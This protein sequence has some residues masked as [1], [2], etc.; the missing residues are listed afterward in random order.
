MPRHF[1]VGSAAS[2][3]DISAQGLWLSGDSD[4]G[5]G[6]GAIGVRRGIHSGTGAVER[7]GGGG[8]RGGAVDSAGR[9]GSDLPGTV[10]FGAGTGDLLRDAAAI[11]ADPR[12]SGGHRREQRQRGA[13]G[14]TA[15]PRGVQEVS[16]G[17]PGLADF[18]HRDLDRSGS[19][20]RG[21]LG[22]GADRKSTRL[23]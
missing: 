22:P 8:S 23:N 14:T 5:G 6:T 10:V 11:D 17:W 20:G 16:D 12:F 7:G 1:G 3:G 18:R 9:L 21:G 13:A 19:A 4:R 2:R 15:A